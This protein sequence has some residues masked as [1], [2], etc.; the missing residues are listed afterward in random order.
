MTRWTTALLALGAGVLAMVAAALYLKP[1]GGFG[2]LLRGPRIDYV[3][4]ALA[5]G[6][7]YA[8]AVWLVRKKPMPAWAM[9]AILAV[10]LAALAARRRRQSVR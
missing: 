1:P 6:A 5:A 3:L 2:A 9:P 10:G 4:L 7:F 8:P